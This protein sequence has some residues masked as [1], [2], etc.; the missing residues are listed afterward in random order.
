MG[1]DATSD[2]EVWSALSQRRSSRWKATLDG[3]FSS[4]ELVGAAGSSRSGGAAPRR[5]R[6][7]VV[8]QVVVPQR[9]HGRRHPPARRADGDAPPLQLQLVHTFDASAMRAE[10]ATAH[11]R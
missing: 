10:L 8:R 3:I 11:A 5:R 4:G 6:H 9:H 1:R 2:A 7:A